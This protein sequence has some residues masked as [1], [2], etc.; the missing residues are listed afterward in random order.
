MRKSKTL[1]RTKTLLQKIILPN[2]DLSFLERINRLDE[3][4]SSFV[5]KGLSKVQ[6]ETLDN[7]D[8]FWSV[9]KESYKLHQE[10]LS[11]EATNLFYDKIFCNDSFI[12]KFELAKQSRL[13]RIRRAEYGGLFSKEEMFHIPFEKR[14]LVSNERFSVNGIPSLYLSESTYICWEEMGNPNFDTCNTSM[15][16]NNKALSVINLT[17]IME[18]FDVNKILKYPLAYVCSLGVNHPGYPF[19]EEYVIPQILMQCLL[20][21][22]KTNP[23]T[24]VVGIRYLSNKAYKER[25]LFPLNEKEGLKRYYN[26]AFPAYGP[27]DNYGLS[28]KLKSLFL[29]SAPDTYGRYRLRTSNMNTEEIRSTDTYIYSAFYQMGNWCYLQWLHDNMLSF[30]KLEGALTF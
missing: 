12:D 10:G 11:A 3:V 26:Y 14:Y 2:S 30:D 8:F 20:I 9:I 15:F 19:K 1:E 7:L 13:F 22:N 27:Y 25:P 28:E 21:Y 16:I 29:W 6:K 4:Y 5:A 18:D 17:P 23:D 24:S